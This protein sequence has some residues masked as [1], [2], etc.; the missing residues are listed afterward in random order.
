M[1]T[2]ETKDDIQRI[3]GK[4]KNELDDINA[5]SEDDGIYDSVKIIESLI[6]DI[7]SSLEEDEEPIELDKIH[8]SSIEY[9]CSDFNDTEIMDALNECLFRG[10]T[11]QQIINVLTAIQ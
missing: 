8:N 9:Q 10:K 4:I 11:H 2:T 1:Y 6:E 3:I 5:I 7:E